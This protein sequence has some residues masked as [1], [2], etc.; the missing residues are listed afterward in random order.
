VYK[1]F[2]RTDW[3]PGNLIASGLI[4]FIWGYLIYMGTVTTIWPMFG[5]ANQLTATIALAVGTTYLINRGKA[6][7][8]WITIIPMA[9]IGITTLT[10]GINN[11]TGIYLPQLTIDKTYVIGLVNLILTL[12]IMASVVII[13]ANAIPKW[14]SVIKKKQFRTQEV[15]LQ[16]DDFSVRAVSFLSS[17]STFFTI[18][19]NRVSAAKMRN[20]SE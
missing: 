20:C 17:S 9:F 3:L 15:F 6:R 14:I 12:V 2:A 13:L 4:V 16:P 7:Y 5:S 1:P 11:I 8:A 10:A 19:G 18:S